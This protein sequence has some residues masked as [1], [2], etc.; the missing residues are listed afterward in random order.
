MVKSKNV[1]GEGINLE[2]CERAGNQA[3]EDEHARLKEGDLVIN[4]TGRGT[5]GRAGVV[6]TCP[7]RVVASVD[8]LICRLNK[9]KITPHYASLFLNSPAGL[10]QSDQF[11]TG[12]SGQLHLYP[13]HIAQFLI[14]LP[15]TKTGQI[16]LAWQETLAAKV[17]TAALAKIEA[18]EKL[19]AAKRLVEA[20]VALNG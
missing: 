11:Q 1:F 6:P 3:W 2:D 16:D 7:P 19:D 5:L 12:S 18:R 15:R 14:F 4:S 20:A 9:Q 17:E 10:A 8:L 13:Q